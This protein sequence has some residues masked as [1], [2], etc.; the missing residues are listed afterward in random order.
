MKA[1]L[2]T[3]T[4]RNL[5]LI[6][7]LLPLALSAATQQK[8]KKIKIEFDVI[9]S[10]NERYVD[11]F[12]IEVFNITDSVPVK[13]DRELWR[14]GKGLLQLETGKLYRASVSKITFDIMTERLRPRSGI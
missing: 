7:L 4:I 8:N 9:Y 12:V 5:T 14:D 6:M 2:T 1:G 13:A 3:H 10:L 11:P